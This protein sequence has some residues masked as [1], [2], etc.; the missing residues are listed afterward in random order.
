[1]NS[2]SSRYLININHSENIK[3]EIISEY[4]NIT[5]LTLII[6]MTMV[7]MLKKLSS[8]S[9]PYFSDLSK[10]V[11]EKDIELDIYITDLI[12][13][14]ELNNQARGKNYA[15]NILSYPS[16]LGAEVI[17]ILPSILLGELV[18][19]HDIVEKQAKEQG[20]TTKQH[21]SHL[22][23][24]GILHLLG[25]DHELGDDKR[26]EMESFEIEVLSHL[27]IPDPYN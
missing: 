1:M 15:T 5:E 8:L 21:L 10:Q 9:F 17:D 18:I 26:I 16:D 22:L 4:Y 24:H 25:F 12:E 13:G 11:W 6:E 20:K 14:R 27:N 19:C 23:I 2:I 3:A 7:V